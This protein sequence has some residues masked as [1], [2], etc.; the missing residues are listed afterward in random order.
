ME[1]KNKYTNTFESPDY[2]FGKLFK[3]FL[4]LEF[5]RSGLK[6][7]KPSDFLL[8]TSELLKQSYEKDKSVFGDKNIIKTLDE[9][10][11]DD[12]GELLELMKIMFPEGI[13]EVGSKKE[14]ETKV[15]DLKTEE[16]EIQLPKR[17]LYS[18]FL[19]R[20][21]ELKPNNSGII[22]FP[23]IFEKLCSSFQ[24]TKKQCWD[25]LFM[26]RD[27]GLIEIV[28]GQGIKVA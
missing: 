18:V 22:R 21:K 19:D 15:N 8:R 12:A 9:L 24:I 23:E 3:E 14:L 5:L 28:K 20:L 2:R 7:G 6:D 17:G 13:K 1:E 25:V 16:K 26:F 11:K 10:M 4:F 27:F